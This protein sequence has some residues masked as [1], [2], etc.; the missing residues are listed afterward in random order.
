VIVKTGIWTKDGKTLTG[1][2]WYNYGAD[3]FFVHIDGCDPAT[4]MR[5]RYFEV[6]GDGPDFGGWKLVDSSTCPT[7]SEP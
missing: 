1:K 4:G 3:C 2:W 5:R 6:S 7:C